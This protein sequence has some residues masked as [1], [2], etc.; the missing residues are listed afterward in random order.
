[1]NYIFFALIF[2]FCSSSTLHAMTGL[3]Y[4][5]AITSAQKEDWKSAH[6]QLNN[7]VI[8]APNRPDLLYDSG[9]ASYKTDNFEEAYAYFDQAAQNSQKDKLLQEKAYFNL[10]NVAVQLEKLEDAIA[11]YEKTL[12]LNPDNQYAKH[13]LETV[14]KMLEQQQQQDQKNDQKDD[15]Q[16]K[17]D[18]KKDEKQEQDKNQQNDNSSQDEKSEDKKEDKG[19]DSDGDNDSGDEGNQEQDK[20][21][22]KDKERNRDEKSEGKQKEE[23][24][25]QKS[26]QKKNGDKGEKQKEERQHDKTPEQQQ[27]DSEDNDKNEAEKKQVN[28]AALAA[29]NDEDLFG[30][31]EQ[32]MARLLRA[33]EDA[34]QDSNKKMIKAMVDDK[35]AGHEGQRCW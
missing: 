1:M 24:R 3:H 21:S 7:L 34:D 28:P 2:F 29:E 4:G 9:V 31:N 35:L 12:E 11:H 15:K 18:Q 14:K 10:G 33:R 13:N 26:D 8:D 22:G 17:Q 23:K 20:K 19:Q 16:D 32:W 30:K 6:D 25:D 27:P 5:R